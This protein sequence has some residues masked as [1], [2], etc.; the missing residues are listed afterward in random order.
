MFK[1]IHAAVNRIA[2]G[3]SFTA[4]GFIAV[5]T[6]ATVNLADLSWTMSGF[7][8]LTHG[9]GIL[10]MEWHYDAEG[11]YQLLTAQGEAG[12]ALYR[13]GLWTLDIVIPIAVSMW[14]AI[15][16]TLA[17]RQLVGWQHRARYLNLLP[18]AAGV[19][20]F[21]ENGLITILLSAY[22]QELSTLANSTGYVTTAKHLLYMISIA[23]VLIGWGLVAYRKRC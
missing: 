21:L 4:F 17:Q 6:V 14:L 7:K 22:P 3:W 15:S 13:L 19:S 23:L 18:I 10:D 9:A 16:I 20:D 5:L 8:Q 12:R 1:S 11:A 2:G